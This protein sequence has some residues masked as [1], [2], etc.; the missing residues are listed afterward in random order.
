MCVHESYIPVD[1]NCNN[2]RSTYQTDYRGKLFFSKK[3]SRKQLDVPFLVNTR[4]INEN[5]RAITPLTKNNQ[6]MLMVFFM[7][8][9]Q[10][11]VIQG[12]KT[13]GRGYIHDDRDFSLAHLFQINVSNISRT[14]G[15]CCF[16]FEFQQ[17]RRRFSFSG[18]G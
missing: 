6:T 11:L 13:S 7:Q 2:L 5:Q 3:K 16:D 15:R 8:L 14:T 17:G 12:G 9:L 1:V 18:R 10:F 4:R